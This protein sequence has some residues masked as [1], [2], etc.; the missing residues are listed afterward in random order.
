[1]GFRG[2]ADVRDSLLRATEAGQKAVEDGLLAG[3]KAVKAGAATASEQ[4]E[5]AYARGQVLDSPSSSQRPPLS[6]FP[7]FLL[8]SF[9]V[10]PPFL[11]CK[12]LSFFAGFHNLLGP[13]SFCPEAI[14]S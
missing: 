10:F 11:G 6:F 14:L 2:V 12:T 13:T 9:V 4:Y 3:A 7:F 8:Y 5:K 1:M